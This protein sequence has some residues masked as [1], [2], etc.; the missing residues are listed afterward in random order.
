MGLD[1]TVTPQMVKEII[2][3]GLK[4]SEIEGYISSATVMFTQYLQPE[5]IPNG[6]Q[7][8]IIKY[9]TAHLIAVMV[10]SDTL[11]SVIIE[12]KIGD[13]SK[14]WAKKDDVVS[15]GICLDSSRWGQ[16]AIMLDPSRVL[17]GLGKNAPPRLTSV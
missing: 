17:G 8:E 15:N 10:P 9:I 6:L 16:M 13:A 5:V 12:E 3:T 2:K 14:K 11:T 1:V 7:I 4:D